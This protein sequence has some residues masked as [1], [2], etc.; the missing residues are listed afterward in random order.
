MQIVFHLLVL[1]NDISSIA[2]LIKRLDGIS[3][4]TARLIPEGWS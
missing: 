2:D 4:S 1:G 3:F